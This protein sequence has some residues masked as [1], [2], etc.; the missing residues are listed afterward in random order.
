MDANPRIALCHEWTTTYGGSDQVAG[1]LAKVLGIRDVYTFA[2]EPDLVAELFPGRTVRAHRLGLHP[3]GRRHWRWLLPAMP[4]AWSRAD[5]S[6]YDVVVT[7]AH[8]C[9]NAI[10][11]RPG[12]AHISYCHTPMRYAWDWREELGRLPPALRPAWPAAAAAL[13]TADRSWA[14]RVTRFVA[15]SRHVAD[16]IR[17]RYGREAAVV[18]PPVDTSFWSPDS[19]QR[20]DGF[21]LLAGRLVPYKRPE[22]AVRAARLAGA[23]LIVA[24]SG[25]ELPKLRQLADDNVTFVPAPSREALREL[26]R[27][28]S[29]LLNPGVEDFGMTMVEAQACGAPVI[30]LGAGGAMEIVSNGETGILYQDASP[31][32][33]SDVLQAFRPSAF[34]PE[35]ARESAMRFDSA[36]F[37]AGIRR[38]MAE[39][40]GESEESLFSAEGGRR[41]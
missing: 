2:A 13:R 11:V 40:L 20:R 34:R 12:A 17:A 6:S 28:A 25:P 32:G 38:V 36:R 39:V 37:D 4:R 41:G 35:G 18:H 5:L 1:R 27:S 9:A 21:F 24:G 7:S 26:F 31:H 30:A 3:M 23:K 15:N 8:A 14:R 19:S 16:R 29:A 33:L 22:V 10:R